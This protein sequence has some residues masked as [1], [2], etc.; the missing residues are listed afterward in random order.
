[1]SPLLTSPPYP[2]ITATCAP[3]PLS[4]LVSA[5]SMWEVCVKRGVAPE[6]G[7]VEH[8]AA[9]LLGHQ[10]LKMLPALAKLLAHDLVPPHLRPKLGRETTV[11]GTQDKPIRRS[12]SQNKIQ[13]G[14]VTTTS[15]KNLD[16]V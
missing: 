15:S 3:P 4:P 6:G 8:A 10:A 1:M 9:L 13:G 2:S 16:K 12:Q 11:T 7:V 5:D 14:P